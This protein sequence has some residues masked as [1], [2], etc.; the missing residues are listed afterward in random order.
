MLFYIHQQHMI[1]D[2][3]TKYE[4]QL[5][6][7]DITQ[8]KHNMYEKVSIITQPWH[9]AKCYFTHE[10][11]MVPDN[12]IKYE[13]SHHIFCSEISKQALYIYEKIAIIFL[14]WHKSQILLYTHQGPMV[15][16]HGT[17]Y[18]ENPASHHIGMHN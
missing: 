10:Q 2:Y 4:Y 18:E 7:S 8:N 3:C 14:I 6:L 11:C 13:Q 16:D 12:C 5:I 17:Q 9:R 1:P 15:P